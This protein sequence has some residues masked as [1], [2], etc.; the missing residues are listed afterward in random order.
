MTSDRQNLSAAR[1]RIAGANPAELRAARRR[2]LA[3][4][5][6]ARGWLAAVPYL[7]SHPGPGRRMA[8]A[9]VVGHDLRLVDELA[10]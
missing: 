5:R 9:L 4:G 6:L 2:R 7:P 8:L 3:R 10:P 1:P